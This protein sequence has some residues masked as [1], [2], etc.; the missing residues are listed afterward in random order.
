MKILKYLWRDKIDLVLLI[1]TIVLAIINISKEASLDNSWLA[2]LSLWMF[3]AIYR[4]GYY[5]SLLQEI[6]TKNI[7]IDYVYHMVLSFIIGF[8]FILAIA[9]LW[10]P[11][12]IF[13]SLILVIIIG[14]GKELIWDKLLKKGTPE[15]QDL[16][17]DTFGGL[18]AMILG[19]IIF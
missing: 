7:R 14:A 10:N 1:A 3:G 5:T 4:M 15:W 13:L 18:A 8:I 2:L 16:Y 6:S 9:L 17:F 11:K 12:Y 19:Y